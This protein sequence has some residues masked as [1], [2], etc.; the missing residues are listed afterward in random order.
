MKDSFDRVFD[1]VKTML[2]VTAHPDDLEIYAG[3]TLARAVK[4]GIRVISVKTTLGEKGSRE[5]YI[6]ESRLK[7][8]RK[9]EDLSSMKILGI[10]EED[11]IY[12]DLGDGSVEHTIENIEKLSFIFRKYNPNLVLTHNPEHKLIRSFEGFTYINHRDHIN[13]GLMTIDA[14][15]PYSRDRNFFP[16]QVIDNGL[17]VA[18][19]SRYLLADYFNHPDNVDIDITN[20]LNIRNEAHSKHQSQFTQEKVLD[21]TD[22]YTKREGTDSRFERFLFIESD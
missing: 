17:N 18:K 7:E 22:Y 15:Y 3:G 4:N 14:A 16:H 2:C 6:E 20:T 11:S 21:T 19:C 9:G 13:T 10:S 1:G 5:D 12:L 8:I